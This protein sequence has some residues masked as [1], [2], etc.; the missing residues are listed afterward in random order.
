MILKLI[1]FMILNKFQESFATKIIQNEISIEKEFLIEFYEPNKSGN[2]SNFLFFDHN[3]YVTGTNYLFKLN[4]LNI[5]D[6]DPKFYKESLINPSNNL[7]KDSS[8]MKNFIKLLIFREKSKDLII[9]GTNLG[10]PHIKDLSVHDFS[11]IVEFDGHYL[12]PGIEN[13]Q[14]LG[15]ISY[16][17]SLNKKSSNKGLM[18]SAIWKTN[19]IHKTTG[20]FARYGIYRQEI[21]L[22]S[23]ILKSLPDSS[24]LWEPNFIY[25]LDYEDKVYYFFTEYSIEEFSETKRMKRV[26]RVARV[27]KN[28]QGLKSKRYANLNNIWASFRKITLNCDGNFYNLIQAKKLQNKII[29]IFYEENNGNILCEISLDQIKEALSHKKFWI[30][31]SLE[32]TN[33][34]LNLYD[35]D[36]NCNNLPSTESLVENSFQNKNLDDEDE[37]YDA[38]RS[39]SKNPAFNKQEDTEILNEFL[40][41]H[42]ILNNRLKA[43]YLISLPSIVTSMSFEFISENNEINF[44]FGT[45]NGSI[46]ILKKHLNYFEEPIILKF[47]DLS[48]ENISE[49]LAQSE[50]I[51][52]GTSEKV[53]QIKI[54]SLLRK[55][56]E[57]SKDCFNCAKFYFCKWESDKCLYENIYI[58][59]P[60]SCNPIVYSL[61]ST[62]SQNIKLESKFKDFLC[63]K[64]KK[65]QG[66]IDKEHFITINGDLLLINITSQNDGLY[67]CVNNKNEILFSYNLK[68]FPKEIE[69]KIDVGFDDKNHEKNRIDSN[70]INNFIQNSSYLFNEIFDYFKNECFNEQ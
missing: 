14:N 60:V 6:K 4:A 29:L 8:M 23:N 3:L 68:V 57:K 16:E 58:T 34:Y 19:R 12:C 39:D 48:M 52:V 15:L 64:W 50:N 28:D 47:D 61:N 63:V 25:I 20:V 10:K 26:S 9:C 69:R 53:Y 22:A 55:F 70:L 67:S 51:Y 45:S 37:F 62:E 7:Y 33:D 56:C 41:K 1:I 54:K 59:V 13:S 65:D 36:F 42:T 17:N 5:S 44:Y 18:Y 30:N 31:R 21:D 27:C 49:I 43:D 46:I 35:K 32:L 40:S 2:Y 24:W 66:S 11:S 38:I